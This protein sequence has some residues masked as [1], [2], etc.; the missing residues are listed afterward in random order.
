MDETSTAEALSG[1]FHT[2]ARHHSY[3]LLPA[4]R[5]S[6]ASDMKTLIAMLMLSLLAG[7]AH[8]EQFSCQVVAISD[9]D[10]FDCVTI[11]NTQIRV[12]M[13]EIDAPERKQPYGP[14]AKQ[15]LAELIYDKLAIIQVHSI[16]RFGRTLARVFIGPLDVNYSMVQQGAAWAY[17]EQLKDQKLR[18][19]ETFAR[20]MDKGL[21]AQPADAIVAPWKWRYAG[22]ING[23]V[24]LQ[25]RQ[26]SS[27]RQF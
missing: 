8:A 10:S 6:L 19:A 15:A 11:A 21:W 3:P 7:Q 25:Q 2:A 5:L 1:F 22:R 12:R 14:Q 17:T 24:N 18:D 9:G 26:Q 27:F 20:N 23:P 13:A 4:L 16:D